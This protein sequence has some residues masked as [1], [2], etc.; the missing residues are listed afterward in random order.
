[1]T[2]DIKPGESGPRV[3][4]VQGLVISKMIDEIYCQ[5]KQVSIVGLNKI[6]K[7]IFFF[8]KRET[9]I[10]VI[11][12]FYDALFLNTRLTPQIIYSS[13]KSLKIIYE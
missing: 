8:Q 1:M 12:L 9:K 11:F 6:I 3:S 7:L 5:Y 10:G 13:I 4:T 2:H